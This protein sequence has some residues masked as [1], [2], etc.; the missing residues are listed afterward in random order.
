MNRSNVRRAVRLLSAA[1]FL[2]Y[3]VPFG[4]L[5]VSY[6]LGGLAATSYN[7]ALP[8]QEPGYC[9]TMLI[10]A[11]GLLSVFQAMILPSRIYVALVYGDPYWM[12]PGSTRHL[13]TADFAYALRV[14]WVTFVT[15]LLALS[16][17]DFSWRRLL[18]P[19]VGARRRATTL[20]AVGLLVTVV[21]VAIVLWRITSGRTLGPWSRRV[22]TGVPVVLLLQGV[23][24]STLAWRARREGAGVPRWLRNLGVCTVVIALLVGALWIILVPT[25]PKWELKWGSLSPDTV[26]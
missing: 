19:G 23:L 14:N 6:G 7:P 12:S 22:V 9:D 1:F 11:E 26:R 3:V 15:W 24:L 16:V 21:W 8:G 18:G 5:I 10:L 4:L 25:M 17:S 13:V 2:A 20:W